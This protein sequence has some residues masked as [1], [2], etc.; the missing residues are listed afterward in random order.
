M[1]GYTAMTLEIGDNFNTVLLALIVALPNILAAVAA[2][3]AK[4]VAAEGR[5]AV[6]DVAAELKPAEGRSNDET[7]T[8]FDKI[9]QLG[10]DTQQSVL[11][12]QASV[13]HIADD[14]AH[15]TTRVD[16]LAGITKEQPT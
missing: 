4:A 10:R 3:R 12:L 14:V 11:A 2:R 13:G 15:L 8:A 6:D 9:T 7:P 16:V 1:T 5:Q